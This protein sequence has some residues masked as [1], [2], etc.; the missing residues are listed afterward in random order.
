MGVPIVR[1]HE[2]SKEG[3]FP[4]GWYNYVTGEIN[5]GKKVV[6]NILPAAPSIFVR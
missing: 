3:Y 6:E 2:T 1:Q 4:G 5:R